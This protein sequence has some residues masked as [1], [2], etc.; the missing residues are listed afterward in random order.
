MEAFLVYNI[1]IDGFIPTAV[2][3]ECQRKNGSS[4]DLT[5]YGLFCIN[6]HLLC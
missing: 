6:G 2:F 1:F 4:F 3:D 5:Q